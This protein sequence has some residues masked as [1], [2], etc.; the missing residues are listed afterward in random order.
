M[1]A[2]EKMLR[3]TYNSDPNEIAEALCED[4]PKY[5]QAVEDYQKILHSMPLSEWLSFLV[6]SEKDKISS[7]G[8]KN[9]IALPM[10]KQQGNSETLFTHHIQQLSLPSIGDSI[11]QGYSQTN[12]ATKTRSNRG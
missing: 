5:A 6:G 3:E 1:R 9:V 2:E 8:I 12:L 10:E 7:N 4:N 11:W